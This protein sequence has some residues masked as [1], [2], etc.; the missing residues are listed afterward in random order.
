VT[1]SVA[2]RK[3][4]M[5]IEKQTSLGKQKDFNESSENGWN[6]SLNVCSV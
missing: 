4:K 3:K 5:K 1:S 6:L 2:R